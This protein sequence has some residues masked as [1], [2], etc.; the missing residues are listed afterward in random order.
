M[1]AK[2]SRNPNSD[3]QV[4]DSYKQE[5]A[6]PAAD[7]KSG[8]ANEEDIDWYPD[9]AKPV[10]ISR[11]S[12]GDISRV[13]DE[14]IDNELRELAKDVEVMS[15]SEKARHVGAGLRIMSMNMKDG[16]SNT[17]LWESQAFK[18]DPN[19][20]SGE[21]TIDVP[22]EILGCRVVS[23]ELKFSSEEEI[24]DF[25]LEQRIILH[26][27]MIERW[28]FH[29]G[30]VIPRSFNSWQQI[31]EAAAPEQ[32]I[33][34]EVLSGNVIFETNFFDGDILLATTKARINYV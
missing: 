9:D 13:A 1:D 33:P 6:F 19:V 16:E 5:R 29:F 28:K 30:F 14:K 26:G 7:S 21:M 23:R 24:E 8:A 25:K 32:M 18:D 11:D 17:L 31:I 20:L 10:L 34:P 2:L 4:K 3:P 15:T 27:Q 22:K 12:H